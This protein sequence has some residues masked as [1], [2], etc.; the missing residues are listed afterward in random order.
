MTDN[1][2]HALIV[3]DFADVTGGQAKVAIDT[4]RLLADAGI[5]VRFLAATGPVSPLL[6]HPN[7][8]VTCLGQHS[9]LDNPSRLRAMLSG[10]WNR[11]AAQA[12]ETEIKR[13]DPRNTVLLCHGWAKAL[14]PS[15]GP[16]LAASRIP[17]L[18][19]MHEYFLACPNGGFF[20]YRAGEICTRRPLSSACCLRNCDARHATHKVW[21]LARAAI[22]RGPGHLPRGLRDIAFISRTQRDVMAPHLPSGTSLHDLP[23]PVAAHGPPVDAA[24][25]RDFVFVGRLAPEKGA[26]IFAKAAQLAGVRAVFVGSGPEEA[27]VRAANPDAEIT[28]WLAPEDVQTHLSRARALVFPSL[29]YECQPLVP[30]EAL[31]RGIPVVCGS[32]SAAREVVQDGVNGVIYDRPDPETLA[33]AIGTV[34]ALDRFDSKTLADAVSPERHLAR[35]TK[36]CNGLLQR[37]AQQVG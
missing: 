32:W 36:I 22:A 26:A 1:M 14:S 10:L 27:A 37:H 30:I 20:D 2:R 31:L 35:L 33:A 19:T 28:G 6:D 11:A 34:D 7:I 3:G 24:Q 4:A 13:H 23:N 21:R 12:L 5:G 8:S 16:V 29:W 15:V 25:N 17:V 9:L 18:Y